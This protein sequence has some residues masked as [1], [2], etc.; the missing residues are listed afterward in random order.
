MVWLGFL[1]RSVV[2]LVKQLDKRMKVY[3]RFKSLPSDEIVVDNGMEQ[4]NILWPYSQ[5]D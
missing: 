1:I 3:F 2:N 5:S 4:G